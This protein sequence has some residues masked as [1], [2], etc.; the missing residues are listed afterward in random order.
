MTLLL[1]V[2]VLQRNVAGWIDREGEGEIDFKEL[3]QEV[4]KPW[5]VRYLQGRL[6]GQRPRQNL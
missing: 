1:L 4:A 3:A 5:Q 6:A 2:R